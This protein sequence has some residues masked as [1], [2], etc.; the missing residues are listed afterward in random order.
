MP[1]KLPVPVGERFGHLTVLGPAPGRYGKSFWLCRCNCGREKAIEASP[2]RKG[3]TV[4]CGEHKPGPIKHGHALNG[5]RHPLYSTWKGMRQRCRDPQAI[6]YPYYGARGISV[7]DRWDSFENF[8]TDM[9]ERPDGH[10]LDRIDPDGN[11]EPSNCRWATREE[12]AANRRD[13]S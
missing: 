12:Q 3:H 1:A 6:S 9:G 5:K 11:Y 8:L 4:S 7:C 13:T 2:L 10:T